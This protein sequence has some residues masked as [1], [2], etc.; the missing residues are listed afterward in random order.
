MNRYFKF[1]IK[2]AKSTAYDSF[3]EYKLCAVLVKNHHIISVGINKQGWNTL[4]ERNN[5]KSYQCNIHAEINALI[6][7]R[8]KIDFSNAS[9]YVVRVRADGSTG[10][11]KPCAMCAKVLMKYKIKK[12]YYTK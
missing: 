5:T 4:S 8:R 1:A 2:K 12:V 11:A 6:G 7:K 3:L 10:I 9:I